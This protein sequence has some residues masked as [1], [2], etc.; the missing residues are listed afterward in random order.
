MP[1]T[2]I[3]RARPLGLVIL[4]TS[5]GFLVV[6]LDVSIVNVALVRIGHALHGGM[7]SLQWVVDAYTLAFAAFLLSAGALGDRLGARRVFVLG[8]GVFGAASLACALA[9]NLPLLIAARAVQGLGAALLMPCSLAVLNHA[10]GDDAPAR[11]RAMGLWTAAGGVALSAGP[12]VGGVLIERFG[13]SSIFYINLPVCLLGVALAWRYLD[14]TPRHHH[15]G[16]LDLAGQC[17]AAAMLLGV[18]GAVIEAGA[19]SWHAPRTWLLL[20]LGML[21]GLAFLC[22]ESRSRA[23]MLP[24]GL[25]RRPAFSAATVVGLV[26]NFALY[27]TIF[28]LSLYFQHVGG[29]SPSATGVAFLPF[30]IAVT[31]ANVLGGR[32]ASRIGPRM[33]M[34]VGLLL[35]AAGFVLLLGVDATTRYAVL[36]ARLLPIPVGVGMAVPS[37]T[38]T[39]L[40]S[41][42]RTR[43]A[44]AAGVL[45]TARQAAG[46]VGV[47]AFGTLAGG[48]IVRGLHMASLLSAALLVLAALTTMLGLRPSTTP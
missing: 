43:S 10:C 16:S 27:G 6:Q 8:L 28:V 45:N 33:P 29:Y 39:V 19:L 23:P 44:L 24:L 40:S 46:A 15:E 31:A 37:M 11:A 3:H 18:T 36:M 1:A 17:C 4:A 25:F 2:T 12:L 34:T 32:L 7:A 42:P 5:L 26:V 41:V 9:P 13:W 38:A 14:E 20:G 21:A 35:G 47:A 22:I 48:D 30:M